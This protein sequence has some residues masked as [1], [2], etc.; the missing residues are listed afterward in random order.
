MPSVPAATAA[1]C[2]VVV[3]NFNGGAFVAQCLE[4]LRGQRA[5]GVDI[6]V[7]VVDNASTDGSA[8][9]IAADFPECRLLRSPTNLGFGGGVNLA[10]AKTTG[11]YIVLLNNDARADD[12]FVAELLAP[13]Q[14]DAAVT[15]RVAAVTGRILL[16]GRFEP[17]P[18][19]TDAYVSAAGVRWRRTTDGGVELVNST[20]SQLSRSGNARDRSWLDPVDSSVPTAEVFGFCGG[21]AALRRSAL[22]DVGTFEQSLFLYYE[23][24]DLSWR[25]RRAGWQIRYAH[26]AVVHHQ[27][28]ASSGISSRLFLVSNVR[29]RLL[30]T[31]RNGPPRMVARAGQRA[32]GNWVKSLAR[33][34][35]GAS[36]P[37]ARRQLVAST[38]ALAQ[39]ARMLPG[40]VRAGRR[41]DRTAA[42]PR[43]FVER[44]L[45]PD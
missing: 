15:D 40:A 8:E 37:P 12:G 5:P 14:S 43:T 1:R 19:D 2:S 23:D 11:D 45:L 18:D 13:L 38:A 34:V 3:V 9:L 10:V 29:N 39:A 7:V 41:T 32:L 42:L 22:D 4:S 17:A 33:S 28:A 21:A 16:T 6:E 24:V 36:R 26:G 25:L 30:V 27:H 44:W 20:G 35:S 31:A